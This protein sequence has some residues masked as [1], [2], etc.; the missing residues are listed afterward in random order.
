M[1]AKEIRKHRNINDIVVKNKEIK[2]SQYAD[3]TGSRESHKACIQTF[4]YYFYEVSG[5][6]LNDK[7]T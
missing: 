3:D 4:F 5:L 6:K 7:K 1:L 2:L